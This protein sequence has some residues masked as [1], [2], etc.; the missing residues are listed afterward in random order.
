MFIFIC[1]EEMFGVGG[2]QRWFWAI[3]KFRNV[4]I[5][6]PVIVAVGGVIFV[7]LFY[8]RN[9][10]PENFTHFVYA[11]LQPSSGWKRP[12]NISTLF[13]DTVPELDMYSFN[14]KEH[15]IILLPEQNVFY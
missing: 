11:Y 7:L 15:Y 3:Q 8:F 6:N 10:A 12:S 13:E 9:L 2:L 1:G 4:T 14:R 5:A